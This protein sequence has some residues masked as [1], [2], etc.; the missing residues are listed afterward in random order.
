MIYLYLQNTPLYENNNRAPLPHPNMFNY[1]TIKKILLL[2]AIILITS[3]R[4]NAQQISLYDKEGYP[5]A[6]IDL[7]NE[8][9]IFLWDGKPIAFIEPENTDTCIFNFTGNFL[10]WYNHGVVYDKNGYIIGGRE[11]IACTV[12]MLEPVKGIQQ[13]PPFKPTTSITP[14]QPIWKNIWSDL[15]LTG[16][17]R[18][19][20]N[21]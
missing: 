8:A 14:I 12:C 9:T 6:Y 13:F 20:K 11:G 4:L 18:S 7:D 16:F 21:N 15:S 5:R 2:G 17:L 10:G 3:V 1:L 19:G